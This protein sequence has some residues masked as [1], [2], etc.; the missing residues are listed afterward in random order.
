LIAHSIFTEAAV[1]VN[2]S[3]TVE[4]R[5]EDYKRSQEARIYNHPGPDARFVLVEKLQTLRASSHE[6]NERLARVIAD[7]GSLPSHHLSDVVAYN[8]HNHTAEETLA[9]ETRKAAL[10][11][12]EERLDEQHNCVDW[13][14][15]ELSTRL[16]EL[17]KEKEA[18]EIVRSLPP[19]TNPH[20]VATEKT[21]IVHEANVQ[22]VTALEV[23]NCLGSF[24][25]VVYLTEPRSLA[26]FRADDHLCGV[27]PL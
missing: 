16:D 7:L 18:R 26:G 14:L 27:D 21:M 6:H 1:M 12:V 22:R 23:R 19:P 3:R 13:K 11:E 4:K 2:R 15:V 20:K 5:Y 25:L 9:E 24:V 17:A 8:E 10:A